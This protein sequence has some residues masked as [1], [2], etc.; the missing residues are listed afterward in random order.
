MGLGSKFEG[1]LAVSLPGLILR[2][3]SLF[4]L[5]NLAPLTGN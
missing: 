5:T 1:I 3:M 2:L 4:R